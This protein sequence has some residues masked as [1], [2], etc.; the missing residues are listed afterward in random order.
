[1]SLN[2][3]IENSL[4]SDISSEDNAHYKEGVYLAD[5]QVK[6][7]ATKAGVSLLCMGY[8]AEA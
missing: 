4:L 8:R 6:C 3:V 1:M 2:E 7:I 5:I